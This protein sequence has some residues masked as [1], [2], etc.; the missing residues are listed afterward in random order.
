MAVPTAELVVDMLVPEE[1]GTSAEGSLGKRAGGSCEGQGRAGEERAPASPSAFGPILTFPHR[2]L[3]QP[4]PHT[5]TLLLPL[6]QAFP[7][8]ANMMSSPLS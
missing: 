7:Q 6:P 3:L 5:Y 4:F 2:F 8:F 1:V